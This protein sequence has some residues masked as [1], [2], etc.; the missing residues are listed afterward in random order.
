MTTAKSID[1]VTKLLNLIDKHMKEK[2][3]GHSAKELLKEY[4]ELTT[5]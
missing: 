4:E 3:C 1:K 5:V 2:E